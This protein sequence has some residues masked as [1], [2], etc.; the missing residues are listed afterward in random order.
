VHVR[1]GAAG[2]SPEQLRELVHWAEGH[3][4]VGDA[5]RR[6]V[7]SRMEIDVA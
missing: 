7:P 3:S 6:A 2:A 1:I 4:P 5:V